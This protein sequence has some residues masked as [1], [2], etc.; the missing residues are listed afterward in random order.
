M[1]LADLS[2]TNFGPFEPR[3]FDEIGGSHATGILENASHV[4]VIGRLLRFLDDPQG[5][6]PL[7]QFH[8][9]FPLQRKCDSQNDQFIEAAVTVGKAQIVP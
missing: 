6:H 1:L 7:G 2:A 5:L 3:L 4:L 8:A 9:I